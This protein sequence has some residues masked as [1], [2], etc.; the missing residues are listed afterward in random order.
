MKPT[1]QSGPRTKCIKTLLDWSRRQFRKVGRVRTPFDDVVPHG[2]QDAPA[3]MA[4]PHEMDATW[5]LR[6]H[7]RADW[8]G[9]DDRIARFAASLIETL[10]KHDVPFYVHMARRT[11]GEQRDL[12]NAGRSKVPGPKAAHT[13]GYAVDIVHARFHWDLTPEE[14]RYVG[15]V[16]KRVAQRLGL[17]VTWGG[18]W[19]FYDPAHWELKGWRDAEVINESLGRLQKTPRYILRNTAHVRGMH[20]DQRVFDRS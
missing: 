12:Y 4:F 20:D 10:R 7:D 5:V 1:P 8:S 3:R 9:V 11:P 19:S 17:G 14:W 18:D 16:G 13:V 15:I 2:V 6:Q